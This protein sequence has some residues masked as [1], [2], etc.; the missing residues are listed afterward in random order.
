MSNIRQ[1]QLLLYDIIRAAT[2]ASCD[3]IPLQF[4]QNVV[5]CCDVSGT[6]IQVFMAVSV[7]L[8]HIKLMVVVF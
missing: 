2:S 1:K 8:R 6:D 4:N 3:T 7:P 5:F